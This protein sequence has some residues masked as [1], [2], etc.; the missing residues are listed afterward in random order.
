MKAAP[1]GINFNRIFIGIGISFD[2]SGDP[3]RSIQEFTELLHG[4]RLK[5]GNG[6]AFFKDSSERSICDFQPFKVGN[7]ERYLMSRICGP[8]ARLRWRHSQEPISTPR[9]L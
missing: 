4:K 1:T 9:R 8:I 3:A 2:F 5:R 7:R 6:S